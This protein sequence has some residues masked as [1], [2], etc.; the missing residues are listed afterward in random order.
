MDDLAPADLVLPAVVID[1]REEVA[2]DPDTS[3]GSRT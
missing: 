1:V 2:E 3:C